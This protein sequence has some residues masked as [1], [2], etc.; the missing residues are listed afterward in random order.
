MIIQ[1]ATPYFS[2]ETFSPD[3]VRMS[4]N[5]YV[6]QQ[7]Q[8]GFNVGQSG[9]PYPSAGTG[10]PG[11][12]PSN[13]GY[14]GYPGGAPAG[15]PA[16]PSYPMPQQQMVVQQPLMQS[17][18]PNP[19]I[20]PGLEHLVSLDQLFIKQKV[21][22]LEA[23]VGFETNN[24][25]TI[26]N[27]SG[28]K[29]FYAVEDVDCCT[30]NCCGPSRPFEMKI[31]DTNQRQVAQ[32]SRPFRCSNF[33]CP[34]FLQR[35]EVCCPPGNVV[36]YVEQDWSIFA[37]KFRI[38]NATGDTILKIEGPFCT[39]QLCGAVEFKVLSRD[40]A[41][42]VGRIS[43]EWG[44]LVREM[45]TDADKFDIS[46]PMDL[47]VKMKMVMMGACFLIDFMFFEKKGNKESDRP[48]MW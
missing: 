19:H 4:S 20:P 18:A 38:T 43:K 47:D 46:F 8:P 16:A 32:F 26:K 37:P 6:T 24:K 39:T 45:F 27:T 41:V 9:A 35:L 7:P 29:C 21:E 5:P 12:P 36:G 30:R 33:W 28:Q 42:E 1:T 48:G 40:G 17:Y 31:F 2:E 13:P 23:F 11:Y 25:Y 3:F 10:Q 15:Y 14:P 34:C 22:L 44:G